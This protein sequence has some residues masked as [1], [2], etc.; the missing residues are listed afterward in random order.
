[1]GCDFYGA[2]AAVGTRV[3]RFVRNAVLVADVARNFLADL[4]DF[5]QVLW[6]ESNA[7]GLQRER[8]QRALGGAL[9][10]FGAENANSVDGGTVLALDGAHSLLQR[11]A[12]LIVIAVGD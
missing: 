10:V 1:M 8:L 9:L 3:G 2:V 11:L 4:V 5:F 7:A 12:A 6:E